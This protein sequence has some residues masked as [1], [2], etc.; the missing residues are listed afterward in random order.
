M[1]S[2]LL[3]FSSKSKG[4]LQSL[5]LLKLSL[6]KKRKIVEIIAASIEINTDLKIV[7]FSKGRAKK[8]ENRVF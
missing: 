5:N 2:F 3:S 8:Q 7:K 1:N 6:V 4:I